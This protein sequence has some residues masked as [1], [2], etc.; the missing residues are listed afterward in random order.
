MLRRVAFR[1]IQGAIE[2][3]YRRYCA[4]KH[5]PVVGRP[6]FDFFVGKDLLQ[7]FLE[8]CDI[9]TDLHID[10]GDQLALWSEQGHRRPSG[11]LAQNVDRPVRQG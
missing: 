10:V 11:G 9:K 7:S 4:R 5:D 2:G 8:L 1:Q 3:R 6:H